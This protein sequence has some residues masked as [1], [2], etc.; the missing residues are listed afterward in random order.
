MEAQISIEEPEN[1]KPIGESAACFIERDGK[2]LLLKRLDGKS[3]GGRYGIPGGKIDPG[4]GPLEA[5]LREVREETGLILT[6]E[7]VH[8]RKKF[9]V[10]YPEYDFVYHVFQALAPLDFSVIL[11]QNEHSDYIWA[12]PEEALSLPLVLGQD[13]VLKDFYSI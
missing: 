3:H 2:H 12:T 7:Q 5:V 6:K 10:R 8:F 1:F 9:Y 4:E 13:T 11:E